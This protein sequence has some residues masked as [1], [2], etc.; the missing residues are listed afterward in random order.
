M[1]QYTNILDLVTVCQY[2]IKTYQYTSLPVDQ[3]IS[4]SIPVRSFKDIYR[5][6]IRDHSVLDS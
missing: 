1:Y 4:V 2:Y 6:S 3:C 5:L